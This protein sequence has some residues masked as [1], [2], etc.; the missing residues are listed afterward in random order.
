MIS[1]ANNGAVTPTSRPSTSSLKK[2]PSTRDGSG[3]VISGN[4][5][6]IDELGALIEDQLVMLQTMHRYLILSSVKFLFLIFSLFSSPFVGAFL[7]RVRAWKTT[8]LGIKEIIAEWLLVQKGWL[9][10]APIF[11]SPDIMITCLL[12]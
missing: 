11:Q 7:T 8:L 10:L 12:L 1:P 2:R 5:G 9:Y 6:S 3:S 4:G